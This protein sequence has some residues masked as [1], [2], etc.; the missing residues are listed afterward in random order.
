MRKFLVSLLVLI[1]LA[2]LFI[3][4]VSFA[5]KAP[6][7]PSQYSTPL[8][9]QKAT[10]KKL[11]EFKE[12]PELTELVRQ[13]KLPSVEK[14][15]PEEPLVIV[16]AEKVGKYGGTWHLVNLIGNIPAHTS[17]YVGYEGLFRWSPDWKILPNIAK[18]YEIKAGGREFTIYLRK[19]IKWSDGAS[20]T[21]DDVMYWY[22]DVL[23]NKELTPVFPI[24]LSPGGAPGKVVKI[25]SYTVK[26]VFSKPYGLFFQYLAQP[27]YGETFQ[28]AHYMKQF[29]I[30][31]AP[32]EKLDAM[33]KDGG[34]QKWYQLYGFK[35]QWWTNPDRPTLYAWKVKT[36]VTGGATQ[37]S[38]DRNPYYWKI[39]TVGN[40]LPYISN[41]VSSI[42]Q[43]QEMARMKAIAGEIDFQSFPIGETV[44]DYSFLMQ[45]RDKGNYRVISSPIGECNELLLFFNMNHKDK[46]MRKILNEPN[47][48]IATSLAIN[49]KEIMEL[50][51]MGVPKD[52]RQP[53]PLPESPYYYEPLAHAYVEYNPNKANQLLDSIGLTKKDKDGY[54]L[55]P[56]GKP[57]LVTIEIPDTKPGWVDVGELITKYWKAVGINATCRAISGT[58]LFQR[59][60][61]SDFDASMYY[62]AGGMM[63]LVDLRGYAPVSGEYW[64]GYQWYQWY[65]SGGKSGETP[66][67]LIQH[68][69]AL[70]KQILITIDE[71]KQKDLF[72]QILDINAKNLPVLGIC[73]RPPIPWVVKNNVR[74]VPES[75]WWSDW[76]YGTGAPIN[77][78]QIFIE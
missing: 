33:I 9:Y 16:P 26:F 71:K 58:L 59:H 43:N 25:D 72:R 66:P 57:L 35:N 42:V 53:A 23:L 22:E 69:I 51:Y 1:L 32:K 78:C 39:D 75:G 61:A 49:R 63:P 60:Q 67:P 29:H 15:L 18:G 47:F 7:S 52:P 73:E 68:Q 40:Q 27:G 77:F 38:L 56:D 12:A 3:S 64:G 45:F 31:Y 20:F 37:W 30:K 24:W 4:S 65:T 6:P 74:N 44:T 50:L 55:R 70:Y 48:R 54:R 11:T 19:G 8:D 5:Q 34:F 2:S 17:L 41:V 76:E 46:V 13:G 28:P 62:A 21:A 10:G 14:R 36:P